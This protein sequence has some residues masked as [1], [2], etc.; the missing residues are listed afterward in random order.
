[1]LHVPFFARDAGDLTL[2]VPLAATEIDPEL[3]KPVPLTQ[4]ASARLTGYVT[5]AAT[6]P[7]AAIELVYSTDAGVTLQVI[8]LATP[9]T[10]NVLG[11]VES[12]WFDMPV[13]MEA[14]VVISARSSAATASTS[15]SSPRSP[16]SSRPRAHPVGP[17]GATGTPVDTTTASIDLAPAPVALDLPVAADV[18]NSTLSGSEDWGEDFCAY[19]DTAAALA[20]YSARFG[21]T[22]GFPYW[23]TDF[24]AFGIAPSA[25]EDVAAEL[26][27]DGCVIER[28]LPYNGGHAAL[29]FDSSVS[30]RAGSAFPMVWMTRHMRDGAPPDNTEADVT[31]TARLF[32]DAST[33]FEDLS[34]SFITPC[35]AQWS[36]GSTSGEAYATIGRRN[37]ETNV[38]AGT[39]HVWVTVRSTNGFAT[40]IQSI[41]CGS[42]A[43]ILGYSPGYE[44]RLRT[45]LSS[46]PLT[47]QILADLNFF[48]A[49]RRRARDDVSG[50]LHE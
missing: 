31:I 36:D 37:P 50:R 10:L 8:P 35:Y 48:A 16:R 22:F 7:G 14:D 26:D 32:I 15:R 17:G 27:A 23:N 18:C 5:Q 39:P 20:A 9:M 11:P 24:D 12:G 49:R 2:T 41:D 40:S 1:V 25:E 38:D 34:T 44:F 28:N 4:Y 30:A 29:V 6:V 46:D 33:V 43:S 47:T 21:T 42:A 45:Y 3:Q 19:M 13:P